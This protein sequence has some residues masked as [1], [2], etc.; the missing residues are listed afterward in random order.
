MA[1]GGE[2][3]IIFLGDATEIDALAAGERFDH[4]PEVTVERAHQRLEVAAGFGI[5]KRQD[6]AGPPGAEPARVGVVEAGDQS[7]AVPGRGGDE[8]IEDTQGLPSPFGIAAGVG[9]AKQVEGVEVVLA[10]EAELDDVA[11]SACRPADGSW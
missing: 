7:E 11:K 8:E 2:Q 3:R 4:A 10:G 1:I 5:G 9:V 6:E